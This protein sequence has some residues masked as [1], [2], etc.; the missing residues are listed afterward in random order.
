MQVNHHAK[1]GYIMKKLI[2]AAMAGIFFLA[3]VGA[4]AAAVDFIPPFDGQHQVISSDS[5]FYSGGVGITERQQMKDMTRDCNLKLVFDTHTGSYL[6]DV[7]VKVQD[8]KGHVLID[9]VANGPW[10]SAK[11]PAG[12]YRVTATFENHKYVRAIKLA[13]RSRTLILSWTV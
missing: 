12:N 1:G 2:F 6:A 5:A 7:N 3:S 11:L 4:A 10:F 13:Q 8:A 9:T